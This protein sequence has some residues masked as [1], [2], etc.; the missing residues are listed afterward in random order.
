MALIRCVDSRKFV[1]NATELREFVV[2]GLPSDKY[3]GGGAYIEFI[4]KTGGE[5]ERKSA[6]DNAYVA[7]ETRVR[8]M[9]GNVAVII[10]KEIGTKIDGAPYLKLTAVAYKSYSGIAVI[11]DTI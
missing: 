5:A 8:E 9:G 4:G 3:Y 2:T 11:D 6:A 1:P 10:H 7:L